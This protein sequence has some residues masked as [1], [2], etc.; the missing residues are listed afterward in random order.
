MIKFY[1]PNFCDPGFDEVNYRLVNLLKENPN[2]FYDNITIGALYGTFPGVIWNGGRVMQGA[3]IGLHYIINLIHNYHQLGVPLRFTYTNLLISEPDQLNDTYANT[4]TALAH[5]KNN[6]ILVANDYLEQYLREV[7]P[8]YKYISSTTKCLLNQQDIVN[9]SEKYYMSVLDY[10]KN[11]DM[12]FLQSLPNPEKFEILINA[13]CRSDCPYRREHYE[14]LSRA[15]LF[16]TPVYA[17]EYIKEENFFTSLGKSHVLTVDEIYNQYVPLG[18]VNF[19]IEGRTYHIV[20]IIET[21]VYY[22]VKPEY[23]D[24]VRA[25]LLKLTKPSGTY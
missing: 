25:D 14:D 6:E 7:Y 18:F 15:Q 21:Y 16:N 4:V 3:D 23:K 13:W 12:E 19:K 5:N 22:L 2:Y 20:D 11:R 8:N 17:C 9:D 1:L 10:R 24:V